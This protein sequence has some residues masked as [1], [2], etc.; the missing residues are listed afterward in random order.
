MGWKIDALKKA[1]EARE[2]KPITTNRNKYNDPNILPVVPKTLPTN[3]S[4]KTLLIVSVLFAI[5]FILN[6]LLMFGLKNSLADKD[7]VI[8]RLER[9]E[10]LENVNNEK[11]ALIANNLV[12][13]KAGFVDLS[14][15]TQESLSVI[16]QLQKTAS[17]N[18]QQID[19]LSRA[20]RDFRNR[21]K[22][23]EEGK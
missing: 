9:I 17:D 18:T 14:K 2:G 22:K 15:Q 10:K 4:S 21:I 16:N 11:T 6:L 12:K 8:L 1:Q 13:L 5:L 7:L 20:D 3:S 23:L 19:S